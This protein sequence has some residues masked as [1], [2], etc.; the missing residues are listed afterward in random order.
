M[1]RIT[2]PHRT[3]KWGFRRSLQ[4]SLFIL[5]NLTL[6]PAEAATPSNWPTTPAPALAAA[7]LAT[8]VHGHTRKHRSRRD[9]HGKDTSCMALVRVRGRGD[10]A[11]TRAFPIQLC[12]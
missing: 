2:L 8:S 4:N 9:G 3:A 11:Q 12:Y 7:V 5:F 1:L 6:A 10:T